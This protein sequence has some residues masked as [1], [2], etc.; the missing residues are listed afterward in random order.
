[1]CHVYCACLWTFNHVLGD[2][3]NISFE[4][5]DD[6]MSTESVFFFV[7]YLATEIRKFIS[8]CVVVVVVA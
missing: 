7:S 5:F 4:T 8:D 6:S 1:M 2:F 3:Y